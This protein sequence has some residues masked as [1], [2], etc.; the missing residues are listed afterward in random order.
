MTTNRRYGFRLDERTIKRMRD[1]EPCPVTLPAQAYGP[2]PLEWTQA[3]PPVWVWVQWTGKPAERRHGYVKG[4]NDRICV[5]WV[6]GDG[7]GR[8][9]AQCGHSAKLRKLVRLVEQG[10]HHALVPR[11]VRAELQTAEEQLYPRWRERDV[12]VGNLHGRSAD[13]AADVLAQER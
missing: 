11:R 12:R 8:E 5:V 9:M 1:Q 7:G 6:D 10:E 4:Y 3:R 13:D 2:Q